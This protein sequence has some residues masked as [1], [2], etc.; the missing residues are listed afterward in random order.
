MPK[1]PDDKKVGGVGSRSTTVRG[2]ES[3]SEVT[4]VKATSGIGGVKGAGAIGKRRP[5]RVMSLA[6]R[7]ELF[8][9]IDEEAEK[10]FA[11]GALPAEKKQ[12]VQQAVKMAVDSGL[13][14]EE[15]E[16]K[17]KE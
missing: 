11:S 10:M 13:M 3:V 1:K 6:E 4:K 15:E 9:L 2:T 16:T 8:N 12:L 7:Q 17:K 14:E 5:T